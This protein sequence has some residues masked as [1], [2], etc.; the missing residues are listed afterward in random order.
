MITRILIDTGPLVALLDESDYFH[1]ECGEQLHSMVLP[2]LTTW[3]VL[4]E[5][6]WLL[7][8]YPEAIQQLFVWAYSRKLTIL[9]MG[10]EAAPWIAT[11][12]RKYRNLD[13][14]VADASLVYF[15][16]REDL[17]TVFTLDRHDFNLYR[18]GRNRR[19]RVIPG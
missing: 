14:D 4:T 1:E 6:T 2:L 10:D 13:P 19:F 3:P 5:T 16:E 9:P 8:S 17:D 12:F 18:F 15:A 7:Q 11:F